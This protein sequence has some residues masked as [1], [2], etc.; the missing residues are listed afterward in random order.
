MYQLCFPS[1]CT[2]RF[3]PFDCGG[4]YGARLH[5]WLKLCQNCS[6]EAA[7][8]VARYNMHH[9]RT[10]EGRLS[11]SLCNHSTLRRIRLDPVCTGD[12]HS[13][14]DHSSSFR[15]DTLNYSVHCSVHHYCIVST[16][17][18]DPGAAPH[19]SSTIRHLMQQWCSQ[20]PRPAA[21]SVQPCHQEGTRAY[22]SRAS[23]EQQHALA[24]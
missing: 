10:Q 14:I 23:S 12:H 15:L 1:Y 19:A 22:Q 20:C 13:V 24:S 3:E 9:L 16:A 21:S 5:R 4:K 7:V 8:T 18:R 6:F 2:A 11:N 17:T